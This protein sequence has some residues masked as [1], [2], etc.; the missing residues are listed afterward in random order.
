[1]LCPKCGM[2]NADGVSFCQN[3]GTALTASQPGYQQPYQTPQYQQT[4]Y[5]Q[6][7]TSSTGLTVMKKECSS[8]IALVAIIAYST[9]ALFSF[10][11]SVSGSSG[12]L[13]YLYQIANAFD[14][15]YMMRD[16]FYMIRSASVAFTIIGMIPTIFIAV[17]LWITYASAASK[18]QVG[19]KTGGLTLVKVILIIN[20]VF[21]CIVFA[22]VEIIA[23][24]AIFNISNSYFGSAMVAPLVGLMIGIAIGMTLIILFYVNAVK[25]I[26]T[27]SLTARTGNPSDKVSVYVAVM[28]FIMGGFMVLSIIT[29]FGVF[30]LLAN[31]CSATAY[32]TFGVFLISYRGKMRVAA[33]GAGYLNAQQPTC[34]PPMPSYS[35]PGAPTP[36][37]ANYNQPM[38]PSHDTTVLT[39]NAPQQIITCS[40]CGGQ[41]GTLQGQ[42]CRCPYCGNIEDE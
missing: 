6:Q 36:Q 19:M 1:M 12:I 29:N 34:V 42:K 35:V 32:I 41:Y 13:R 8:P 11:N 22:I 31:L 3:C 2:Q 40:K 5:T 17:G 30:A 25:T 10:I 21:K 4:T 16:L 39:G 7:P 15:E 23:I 27:I 14:M 33:N 24:V 28:S 26:N 18:S 37:S 38:A 9:A 20:L